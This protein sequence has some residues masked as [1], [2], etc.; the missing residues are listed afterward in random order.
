MS[1]GCGCGCHDCGKSKQ[2]S[3]RQETKSRCENSCNPVGAAIL[4]G[5]IGGIIAGPIGVAI[6]ATLGA[7]SCSSCETKPT[8]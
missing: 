6:G 7:V 4:L 3:V 8:K 2:V 5:T 1:C